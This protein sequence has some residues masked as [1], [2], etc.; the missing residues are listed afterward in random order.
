MKLFQAAHGLAQLQ[1]V[2]SARVLVKLIV[3]VRLHVLGIAQVQLVLPA[4]LLLIKLFARMI[5]PALGL[6]QAAPMP[7]AAVGRV[8][9]KANM[10]KNKPLLMP[11]SHWKLKKK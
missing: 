11:T 8:D 4:A 1:V 7:A 9:W 10:N 3:E 2:P 6:V 5:R